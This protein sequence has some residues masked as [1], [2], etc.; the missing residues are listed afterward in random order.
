MLR[1]YYALHRRWPAAILLGWLLVGAL[2]LPP[3]AGQA[4]L[5]PADNL[6]ATPTGLDVY[7]P[8]WRQPVSRAARAP[9]TPPDGVDLEVTFI[10]RTPAYYRYCVD[11]ASGKPLVCAGTE[12]EQRWPTPGE[13]VTFSGHIRNQG[14][15]PSPAFDY[16]WALDD[17]VVL[18]GVLPSL[19]AGAGTTVTYAWPWG[20]SMD[21]ERVLDDHTVTL[22]VDPAGLVAE[23]YETNNAVRDYTNAMT[24]MFHV[25]PAMMTGYAQPWD[26]QWPFSAENWFQRQIAAMNWALENAI[27]P[28][29]PDGAR[30]RVRLDVI[31]VSDAPPIV[32]RQHD[33]YW[34]VDADYRTYSGGYDPATD[35]DW[36][37]VHELS[38][39][40]GLIDLYTYNVFDS[41]TQVVDQWGYPVNF[42]DFWARPD[43]MGGGDIAPYTEWYRYSNHTAGGAASTAGYRRGYYGEYQFDIPQQVTLELLDNSDQPAA[44]VTVRLYQRNGSADWVG[45]IRVDNMPEI[46]GLSDADGRFLL[47]NRS[48]DGSVTTATGHTLHDNPFGPVDVVGPRNR[49][50]I[51]VQRDIYQEFYWLDVTDLNMAYWAGQLESYTLTLHTHLPAADAPA[52]PHFTTVRVQNFSQTLCWGYTE[53]TP[54]DVVSYHVYRIAPPEFAIYARVAEAVA[55]PCYT[56][57]TGDAGL[58]YAVFAVTA[59]DD[60]GRESGFSPLRWLP[61]LVYVTEVQRRPDGNLL[62]LDRHFGRILL[63]EPGGRYVQP[64]NSP[65]FGLV[66]VDYFAVNPENWLY[67]SN[68]S[69]SAYIQI[70]TPDLQPG[71]GFG[72]NEFANPRGIHIPTAPA[73]TFGGPYAADDHTW[74][75]LH[76]NDSYIGAQGELPVIPPTTSFTTGRFGSGVLVDDMDDTLLYM[77]A[78]NLNRAQGAIEMWFRPNWNGN[79]EQNYVLFEAGNSWFNR[80][81]IAKDGAN[82]LRF[83]VWD[84]H[85]EYGAGFHVADWQAG[86][87]H[88]IA[89]TWSGSILRLYVDGIPRSLDDDAHPPVVAP[90]QLGIGWSL[91]D[92]SRAHGVLDEVRISNIPRIGNSDV[93]QP[94]IFIADAL[95][96]ESGR[97]TVYT[98]DGFGLVDHSGLIHPEGVTATPDGRVVVA[99]RG[100][101]QLHVYT[102]NYDENA[103]PNTWLTWQRNI[104]ADLDT[105]THLTAY[106]NTYLVV[107]DTAHNAVK[108]FYAEALYATYSTPNDGSG[109]VFN[110]PLGVATLPDGTIVVADSGNQRIVQLQHVLP[111]LPQPHPMTLWLPV[112]VKP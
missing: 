57:A 16:A 81:R 79:D 61:S 77:A 54:L 95:P 20:H 32:D 15:Q 27:Y 12:N 67:I 44:D 78:G 37:L 41:T 93:C 18:T 112:G 71:A 3:V 43:L 92:G 97:L 24:L 53:S 86:D 50:L 6:P 17:S 80:L 33:G 52:A 21:G 70:A 74:L 7:A 63:Q 2:C 94:F 69:P 101:N 48:V 103:P 110:Q 36:N 65:H 96:Y 26:A 88:H 22:T 34:F 4:Q 35:I 91:F 1:P 99:D 75:L 39:Q 109:G 45:D 84:G 13:I 107:A 59:V 56:R 51:S 83:M 106:D 11:Y 31:A 42:S 64:L 14:T 10:Q 108:V 66:G 8:A 23:T 19:A 55:G 98:S 9:L 111:P 30:L 76:L 82:Y 104:A 89:V 100:D 5:S 29:T 73:C 72:M 46:S 105:P 62:V 90:N 38:H 102:F 25:T 58:D 85:T 28:T 40:I 47:P 49:F 87:W 68:P 60:Q